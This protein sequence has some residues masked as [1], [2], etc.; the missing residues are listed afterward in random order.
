MGLKERLEFFAAAD[1]LLVIPPR[2]SKMTVLMNIIINTLW[3]VY[4]RDGLNRMPIEFTL[5]RHRLGYI[6][7]G[8]PPPSSRPRTASEGSV[9]GIGKMYYCSA[10]PVFIFC[11]GNSTSNLSEGLVII[12]EFVSTARVMRGAIVVNPWKFDEV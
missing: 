3:F 7:G 1:I 2:Y 4:N 8:P 6:L 12:S 10:I 5:A 9:F 11:I